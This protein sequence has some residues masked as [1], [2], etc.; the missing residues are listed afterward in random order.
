MRGLEEL[1]VGK[2]QPDASW[3][4]GIGHLLI[5]MKCDRELAAI[6]TAEVADKFENEGRQAAVQH[7]DSRF[8]ATGRIK[9]VAITTG[10][11][12]ADKHLNELGLPIPAGN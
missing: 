7:I 6:L 4:G 9:F 12:E 2:I 5:E 1:K 3:S 8:L 11:R 10:D